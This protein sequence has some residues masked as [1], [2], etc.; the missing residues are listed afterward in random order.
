MSKRRKDG[1]GPDDP[2][3]QKL[4][5]AL[6]EEPGLM[7]A[8]VQETLRRGEEE[9]SA[10]A[11]SSSTPITTKKSDDTSSP[12]TPLPPKRN[13]TSQIVGHRITVDSPNQAEEIRKFLA[14]YEVDTVIFDQG[15]WIYLRQR[16][17]AVEERDAPKDVPDPKSDI[18]RP[19]NR[20]G[21]GED[22]SSDPED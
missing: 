11:S 18:Q 7:R 16:A 8:V 13:F 1:A 15:K 10:A 3:K 22:G 20:G 21:N 4:D 2:L 14:Q 6:T 19:D 5:K 9:E 12:Q 17:Y